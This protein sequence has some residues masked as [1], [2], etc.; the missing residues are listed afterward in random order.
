MNFLVRGTVARIWQMMSCD[1]A[2]SHPRIQGIR[3]SQS[4]DPKASL[5]GSC[6]DTEVALAPFAGIS[7]EKSTAVPDASVKIFENSGQQNSVANIRIKYALRPTPCAANQVRNHAALSFSMGD[8]Q[9]AL[10]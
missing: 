5:D 10:A 1:T 2:Q 3:L 8:E 6:P 9:G 4:L 7:G